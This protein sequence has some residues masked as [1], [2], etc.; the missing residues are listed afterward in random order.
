LI[1]TPALFAPDPDAV[2]TALTALVRTAP[3]RN[4]SGLSVTLVENAP[5]AWTLLHWP[6]ADWYSRY[7][8]AGGATPMLDPARW[9]AKKATAVPLTL[10]GAGHVY[11]STLVRGDRSPAYELQ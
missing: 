11:V 3:N 7:H 6:P 10:T 1:P 2:S 4:S 5:L 8:D 9:S